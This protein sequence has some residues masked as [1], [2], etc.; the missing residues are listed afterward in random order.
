MNAWGHQSLD[1]DHSRAV[2]NNDSSIL[3]CAFWAGGSGHRSRHH[4][5]VSA[6]NRCHVT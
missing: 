4:V 6:V 3:R 5:V 1:G 2:S